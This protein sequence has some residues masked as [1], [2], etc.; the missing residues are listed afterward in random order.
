MNFTTFEYFPRMTYHREYALRM[1]M[2]I[3]DP[4]ECPFPY[5]QIFDLDRI[6]DFQDAIDHGYL[7]VAAS[8]GD[9]YRMVP[10]DISPNGAGSPAPCYERYRTR[11]EEANG[12]VVEVQTELKGI[13]SRWAASVAQQDG[14]RMDAARAAL[15]AGDLETAA[16]YGRVYRLEPVDV[17]P[18]VKPWR[19]SEKEAKWKAG[20]ES[21]SQATA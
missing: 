6:E 8:Q 3:P 17:E 15:A 1:E 12:Y 13:G 16:Q 10:L 2:S 7:N 20:Q 9:L 4:N 5:I 11:M 14:K 18:L 19:P 21:E